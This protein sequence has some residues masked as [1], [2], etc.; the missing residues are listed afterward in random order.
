MTHDLHSEGLNRRRWLKKTA[1][2]LAGS[3]LAGGLSLSTRFA[4]AAD[5]KALVCIFLYGGNDGMNMLVPT[6]TTRYNQYAGVRSALAL[7]RQSLVGLGSSGY[8]LHPAMAALAPHW[9]QGTLAPV[10]NVGPLA[11]PL[12]KAQYLA[13]PEG[14]PLIPDNLF[15]HSDQQI[16]WECA[17]T[18]ALARTGWG[19][20]ASSTL[21]TTNPVISVGG[22]GHFGV[23]DLRTPLVLPGPGSGFGAYG[24]RPEDTTWEPN[25]LRKLAIDALYAQAQT[26][27]L[28]TAYAGQQAGAFEISQRLSGLV[29]TMPG[30]AQAV[31]AIDAAFAGLVQDGYFS[32]QLAAQLYQVAKLIHGHGTVQGDRQIFFAQMGG[33][34]THSGQ[35][36]SGDAA[37]GEHAVLLKQLA[38]ALAAFQTALQGIAMAQ[39]VTSFTQADFGRTFAPNSS[40]GTDHAWGNHQL[41]L[42]GAVKGGLTYGSYPTLVLG[43]PDD[44]GVED[45]ELQGRWIPTSA[46]DQYAATLLSWFGATDAQLNAA[47]P[48]L[49]NFGSRRTLGF[50]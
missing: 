27:D 39:Q 46:V 33:F 18:D 1:A 47:L 9:N 35:A 5:Y 38:D 40:T 49:A 21:A 30:D 34:D 43:G 37:S 45:W 26:V 17:G 28:A 22:N 32:S 42:G 12:T 24:L 3:G 13:E 41:V 14:S 48:N 50:L 6:D 29:A 7:P 31:P 15:S 8:G 4:Q 25:R 23:E 11:A 36:Y 19:G 2:L 44:V 16:L 20:R 10:F